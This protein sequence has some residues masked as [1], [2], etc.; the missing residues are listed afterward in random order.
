MVLI[1]SK[2]TRSASNS[3]H[4]SCACKSPQITM[5]ALNELKS[6]L[7][8]NMEKILREINVKFT[9]IK[10]DINLVKEVAVRADC[11]P[12]KNEATIL[13]L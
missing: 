1:S 7:K 6:A 8:V 13:K 4:Q 11:Q 10:M 3:W 12:T 2:Q 5:V 9:E